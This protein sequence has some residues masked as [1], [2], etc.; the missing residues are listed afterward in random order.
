MCMTWAFLRRIMAK[1]FPDAWEE[2]TFHIDYQKLYEL[3][4]R[5]L[6][7]DIDNTLVFDCAPAD[8]RAIRFLDEIRKMGFEV[9][10]LSN[11]NERRVKMFNEEIGARFIFHAGKPKPDGYLKAMEMMGTTREN[12]VFIGDQVFTDVWG[13]KNAGV[14]VIMVKRLGPKEEK[15][16]LVKRVLEQPVMLAFR[17][18]GGRKKKFY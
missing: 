6:I 1:L 12:T 3:G 4:Y 2:S 18:S 13:A 9:C 10:L 15:H 8:E 17:L 16:I 7:F 14:K 11:N 5:G